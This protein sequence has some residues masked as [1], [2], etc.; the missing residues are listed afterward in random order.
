MGIRSTARVLKISA[1]TLLKRIVEIAKVIIPPVFSLGKVYEIDEINTFLKSKNNRL[2]I[3]YAIERCSKVV[4]NF[5]IGKRTSSTLNIVVDSLNTFQPIAI[6]SD[7]LRN[8]KYLINQSI[9]KVKRY[10]TNYI[11]RKN[12]TLRTHIK[13]LNRKTIC[14][15]KKE[16]YLEAILKIYFWSKVKF[17]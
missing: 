12:L 14:F 11:E 3:V 4:V 9:H 16:A 10:G 2:W 17:I 15:S 7:K 1:T 5:T 8:Y 6:Y 13:R